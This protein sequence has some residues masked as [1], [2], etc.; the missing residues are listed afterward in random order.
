MSGRPRPLS[1]QV[2]CGKRHRDKV[3]LRSLPLQCIQADHRSPAHHN[4]ATPASSGYPIT[5]LS[6]QSHRTHRVHAWPRRTSPGTAACGGGDGEACVEDPCPGLHAQGT[7]DRM[8]MTS[9]DVNVDNVAVAT[10]RV[11]LPAYRVL[12]DTHVRAAIADRA[13]RLGLE[14]SPCNVVLHVSSATRG[15]TDGSFASVTDCLTA[16]WVGSAAQGAGPSTGQLR[17]VVMALGQHEPALVHLIRK[18]VTSEAADREC[19]RVGR[20]AFAGCA[21]LVAVQLPPHMHTIDQCAFDSCVSLEHVAL[22][23][24]LTYIGDG[25]F[26]NCVA[27]SIVHLPPSLCAVGTA[28]FAGCIGLR[29]VTFPSSLQT[30]GASAFAGCRSLANLHLPR[31]VRTIGGSGFAGCEAL[32]SVVLP[33]GLGVIGGSAFA[34]CVGLTSIRLPNTVGY[35]GS[36]A[37]AGCT[38]LESIALPFSV[39][40]VGANAFARCTSLEMVVIPSAAWIGKSIF[41][42]SPCFLK[43][44][45]RNIRIKV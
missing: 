35:V 33:H 20:R 14:G 39:T 43:G 28:A 2:G 36:S 13:Q 18:L 21:R 1:S 10:V 3:P 7:D 8:D 40:V 17:E 29:D 12:S 22:S 27:L 11:S 41:H 23:P 37:F 6:A 32:G 38:R 25:A 5:S 19:G 4:N 26:R 16:V 24:T 34:G 9:A 31:S 44:V 42:G 45:M 30:I 15:F